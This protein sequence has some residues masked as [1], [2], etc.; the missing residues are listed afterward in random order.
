MFELRT[1]EKKEVRVCNGERGNYE[2]LTV[3]W[4]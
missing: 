4:H 1:F 3:V 2:V